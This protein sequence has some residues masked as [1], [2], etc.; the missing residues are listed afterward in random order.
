M[1]ERTQHPWRSEVKPWKNI[2]LVTV[3]RRCARY[4][5]HLAPAHLAELD[6]ITLAHLARVKGLS[7]DQWDAR[8]RQLESQTA[9]EVICMCVP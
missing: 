4:L 8:A 3:Q 2:S 5:A 7:K 6:R 9:C 1:A